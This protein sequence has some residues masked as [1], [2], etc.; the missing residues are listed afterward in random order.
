MLKKNNFSWTHEA[1]EAFSALKSALTTTPVLA[2]PDFTKSF[3]VETDASGNGIG[4]V[5][6]QDKHP[7][8][9][10][11]K[12]LSGRNLNMST[13]DKEMMAIIYAVQ[14][15]RPYLLGSEFTIIT[16]HKALQHFLEQRISTP[17]QHKWLAKLLGYNYKVVFRPGALNSASDSL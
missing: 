9:Y 1:E 6:S 13:Y 2:L 7:R 8:A 14:K 10:I 16:D 12:A 11:G 5:L 3:V 4:A 17:S 15:W